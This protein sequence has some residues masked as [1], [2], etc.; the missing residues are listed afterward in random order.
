MSI[1]MGGI[2]N[3][4]KEWCPVKRSGYV[5]VVSFSRHSTA[6]IVLCCT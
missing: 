4:T 3:E 1:L 2:A 5:L 6:F